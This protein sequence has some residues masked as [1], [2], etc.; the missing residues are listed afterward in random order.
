MAKNNSFG[1]RINHC[2]LERISVVVNTYLKRKLCVSVQNE[3]SLKMH[4]IGTENK[5]ESSEYQ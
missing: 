2:S 3:F 1:I 4:L 5:T